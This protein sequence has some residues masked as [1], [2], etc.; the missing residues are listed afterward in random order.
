M[1]KRLRLLVVFLLVMVLLIPTVIYAATQAPV[2]IEEGLPILVT[3]SPYGIGTMP[4]RQTFYAAGRNW[5]FYLDYDGASSDLV[6][7]SAVPGTAWAANT[8]VANDCGLY[9]VEYAIFYDAENDTIHYARHDMTP[10]PDEVKYRMGTPGTNGTITWAAAE[11]TV[12][13]TP[14]ALLTWRTTIAVDEEGYPWV[15]W[16][17]TDGT[18]LVGIVYVESSSTK[19]GTWTEAERITCGTGGTATDGTGTMTGSPVTLSDGLNQPTVTVEGTFIINLPIGGSG[20]A[21]SGGWAITGSPVALAEGDNTITVEAAGAGTIDIDLDLDDHAWFVALTPVSTYDTNVM[22]VQW[23]AEN[24]T[25]GAADGD[26]G[27]YATMYNGDTDTWSTRDTVVAEGSLNATRPDAFSFYDIGSSM[28]VVYTDSLGSLMC[29]ARSSIQTWAVCAAAEVI[30]EDP[31]N[32]LLPTLSGY[33]QSGAG[34]NLICIANNDSTLWYAF[35]DYGDDI[36]EWG[37][38]NTAW[39]A[40]DPSDVITRHVASYNFNPITGD[41]YGVDVLGFAW[42]VTDASDAPDTDNLYFWWIDNDNDQLGW[43]GNATNSGQP[44]NEIIPI[45]L[46]AF[47]LILMLGVMAKGELDVYTII[48][49]AVMIMILI[50]F[51]AGIQTTIN[52]MD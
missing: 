18:N 19:N 13:T 23:S 24:R 29:R 44:L 15:A 36:D 22:E 32:I 47:L 50:A 46:V 17:D 20:T 51:L 7:T 25:G 38:W 21:T 5:I 31:G 27:L 42:Q 35:H 39:Q 26:N 43:Y 11:Q 1:N 8:M 4:V 49:V 33:S 41:A 45:L 34:D 9:G 12:S 30:K 48:I 40:S 37:T 28:W 52:L 16:I 10:D 2:L 3:N 14:A 6:Y